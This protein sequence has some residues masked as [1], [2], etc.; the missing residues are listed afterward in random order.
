MQAH[1]E[2]NS[3]VSHQATQI[4]KL[5]EGQGLEIKINL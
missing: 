2:V 1:S 3:S 4:Q 5:R